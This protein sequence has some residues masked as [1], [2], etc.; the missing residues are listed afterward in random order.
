MQ[1]G[2][3]SRELVKQPIPATF[4]QMSPAAELSNTSSHESQAPLEPGTDN[5]KSFHWLCMGVAGLS[6]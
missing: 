5:L 4:R 6:S 1:H 3:H 2:G